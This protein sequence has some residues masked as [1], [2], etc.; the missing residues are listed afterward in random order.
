MEESHKSKDLRQY[1]SG[2][3]WRWLARQ[4]LQPCTCPAS[5]LPLV[6]VFSVNCL[7]SSALNRIRMDGLRF[8]YKNNL[9]LLLISVACQII[10]LFISLFSLYIWF[11][12]ITNF[13]CGNLFQLSFSIL[14]KIYGK[15]LE[16]FDTLYKRVVVHKKNSKV[17]VDP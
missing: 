16:K 13:N 6:S 11:I 17:S 12:L 3:S 14:E 5:L 15:K 10:S 9:T 8:M 1:Y 7:P 4:K 2:R